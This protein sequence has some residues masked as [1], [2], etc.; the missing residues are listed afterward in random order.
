M[1]N[2]IIQLKKD[3]KTLLP[4]WY[5]LGDKSLLTEQTEDSVKSILNTYYLFPIAGITINNT[6]DDI[7]KLINERFQTLLSAIYSA[8]IEIVTVLKG[9]KGGIDFYIGFKALDGT[10]IE[11]NYYIS[12]LNGIFPGENIE[13]HKEEFSSMFSE[14]SYGGLI[15]GIPA[16]KDEDQNNYFNISTIVR[17]LYGKDYTI[18]IK[19]SPI[20]HSAMQEQLNDLFIIKDRCHKFSVQTVSEDNGSSKSV[21]QTK[22]INNNPNILHSFC[23]TTFGTERKWFFP[24]DS[25][26]SDGETHSDMKSYS[27]SI[28]FEDQNSLAIELENIADH[29]I[30]RIKQG[31][32]IGYWETSISFAT[33]DK[34]TSDILGGSFVGE[35]SKPSDKLYPPRLYTDEINPNKYLFLPKTD[36][37]I[38]SIFPKSLSSYLT[39]S[40]LSLIASPSSEALPGYEIKK[41]PQLSLTDKTI[42][43]E[44]KLGNIA[45][46]GIG[47]KDSIVSLSKSDLNKHL[48]VC[49]LTG[50]GKSTT[51]K[52]II[53]ECYQND[54]IPFLVIESAKRDYRQLLA[55]DCLEN[56]LRVFTVGDSTISPIRINPFYVQQNTHPLVHIDYLKSIFNASFSLYGPMPHIVEKCLHN[57]YSQR[58]WDLTTGKHPHFIDEN[59]NFDFSHYENPEHFYCFPTLTD[60]KLEVD[61]YIKNELDYKGELRD[62]IR[63]A[64]ITRIESLCVGAKGQMFNTYDFYSIEKLLSE[65]TIL[66]MENLA[67]DDDKAFFVGLILVLVNEYRQAEN[68]TMKPGAE[69]K[70][71]RH[72][73]VIEEAHRLLKNVSTEKGNEMTGNPKGKAVEFFC[74]AIAEMRSLGQGVIV[75]EQ[76]PSK[77]SPDVIK[78]S[79]TK[80]VH[81]LVSKDDQALLSGALSISEDDAL[82]LNRLKTGYALIHKEGME[83]PIE[84]NI[85]NI[86]KG[87]SYD[88]DTIMNIMEGKGNNSLHLSSSYEIIEKL[89]EKGREEVIKFFNSLCL[90]E[91]ANFKKLHNVFFKNL[92]KQLAINDIYI[93]LDEN[94]FADYLTLNIIKLLSKGVYSRRNKIPHNMKNTISR[95]LKSEL[96]LDELKKLLKEFWGKEPINHIVHIVKEFTICHLRKVEL[97]KNDSDLDNIIK[98]SFYIIDY[99]EVL[100]IKNLIQSKND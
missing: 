94:I 12:I 69:K 54:K 15:T 33:K 81:R 25:S 19:S 13:L 95:V 75:A 17:S 99:Y 68:P 77:I 65:P 50:S 29:F 72:L 37:S 86:I 78:N 2:A 79:N 39:S 93:D 73:F 64:I 56:N 49:G 4:W 63:T 43:G 45:D 59:G 66:E 89:G 18:V 23:D 61:N 22:T 74:N 84:C 96:N 24:K 88:N 27:K 3:F 14:M 98:S 52:H 31:F 21:S 92:I 9:N 46:F 1:D 16:L 60:L 20:Q 51:I 90:I 83:R 10:N 38:S 26:G 97:N 57:I 41:M 87:Y 42:N 58:G 44:I 82:Y 76:I 7:P 55:E 53:K 6:I 36:V 80:I 48:F 11:P 62:N 8:K 100:V 70:G 91:N 47:I 30:E 32:N 28:S 67:D 71:L 34:V 5:N 40:E 35:I 85:F